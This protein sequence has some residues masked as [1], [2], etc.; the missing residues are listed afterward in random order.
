MP[1][2]VACAVPEYLLPTGHRADIGLVD[3]SGRL[4]AVLEILVAHPVDPDKEA[5]LTQT[6]AW[7]EFEARTI[8]SSGTWKPIRDR[9]RPHV[10][11][12]CRLIER[13]CG[14]RPWTGPTARHVLCPRRHGEPVVAVDACA[15]CCGF[16]K[17]QASGV[18]CVG[19]ASLD[20]AR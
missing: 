3:A 2:T 5:V 8:L 15:G 6:V 7:A 12:D 17:V 16:V 19:E 1:L 9:F 10:C 4:L 20:A 13:C 14:V 18:E 11:H